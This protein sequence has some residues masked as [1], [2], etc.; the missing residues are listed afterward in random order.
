ME[1]DVLAFL[2]ARI[3]KQ[4]HVSGGRKRSKQLRSHVCS[5]VSGIG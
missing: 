5:K 1:Y 2:N 4:Q 3:Y